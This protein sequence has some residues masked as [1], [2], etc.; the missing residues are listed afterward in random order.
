M[1]GERG[2]LVLPQATRSRLNI[3]SGD[4]LVLVEAE[5]GVVLMPRQALL[6]RVRAEFAGTPLVEELLADR[7]EA[8][9]D[10]DRA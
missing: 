5:D 10:E 1:V 6:R 2:R 9:R 4:V 8:S 3:E 7:R